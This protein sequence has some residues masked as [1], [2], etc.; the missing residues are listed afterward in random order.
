MALLAVVAIAA[1]ALLP[2]LGLTE[3]YTKGE[4]R[5]AVVALSMINDGNWILPINNGGDIPYKPPFFHFCI[6]IISMLGGGVTELTSRLPSALSLIAMLAAV[7]AFYSRR[8]GTMVAFVASMLCLTSFE[9]HRAGMACRVDMMLSAFTVGALLLLYRWHERGCR[10]VPVW[11][12]LCMSGAVLTK[13]PVG[14]VVPCFAMGVY[15]LLRGA[16]LWATAW[17]LAL[18]GM[19]SLIIPACWYVAA[20]AQGGQRFLDL[21]IEENFG[22]MTGTMSYGSHEH[23]APYNLYTLV[24]GWLPWTLVAL[25]ALFALPWHTYIDKVKQSTCTREPK[26]TLLIRVKVRLTDILARIRRAD[27]TNVFTWTAFVCVL[28]FYC[29]PSSK[30]SVYLLPCYPFIAVLLAQMVCWLAQS[31]R[32][33]PLMVYACVMAVIGVVLTATFVALRLGAVPDSIFHGKHAAQNIVMLHA[34]SQSHLGF[35]PMLLALLPGTVGVATLA[36]FASKLPFSSCSKRLIGAAVVNVLAIFFALDGCLQPAVLN[37]K[38]LRPMAEIIDRQFG[39]E[40]LYSYISTPMMH[41]FGANFYLNNR[42]GLFEDQTQSCADDAVVVKV[43][44]P[45]RGVL[46]IPQADCEAFMARHTNYTFQPAGFV[47]DGMSE[48]KGTICFFRF[49]KGVSICA[50]KH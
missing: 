21:V 50:K 25:F 43:P 5:E 36:V 20:Y 49:A 22:R 32:R 39:G 44:T 47:P 48:T 10:G 12:V 41:F 26:G 35:V 42:I 9:V 19:L 24:V 11:A 23:S 30:R 17:R 13:G 46:I 40:P 33:R 14:M 18:L 27:A 3:F 16:K 28:L 31:G 7:C 2:W 1:V 4:P 6:A 38:S 15:M 29:I 8:S 34:L 45:Q 37:T